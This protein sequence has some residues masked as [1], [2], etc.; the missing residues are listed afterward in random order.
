M[1]LD[2]CCTT[3][4]LFGCFQINFEP[5]IQYKIQNNGGLRDNF[6][7]TCQSKN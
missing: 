2:A 7:L 6:G 1:T 3:L 4:D 5:G